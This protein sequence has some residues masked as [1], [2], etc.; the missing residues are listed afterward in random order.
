MSFILNSDY[1]DVD[2]NTTVEYI[3]AKELFLLNNRF[4]LIFKY[5]FIK[6]FEIKNTNFFKDLYLNSIKAFNNFYEYDGSKISKEDFY[7]SFINLLDSI[8]NNGFNE[9]LGVIPV[10]ENY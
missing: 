8:K 7:E 3:D 2:Y 9:N 6:Y 4:D 1:A 5:I 10:D